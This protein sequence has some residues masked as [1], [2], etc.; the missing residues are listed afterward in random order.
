MD[1][2]YII[3]GRESC[4]YCVKA[5]N[6]LKRKNKTFHFLDLENEDEI[7][8]EVKEYYSHFTV[9]IVLKCDEHFSWHIVGGY[10][11][12]KNSL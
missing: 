5:K 12:L 7:L 9:P 3:F 4:P 6:L 1:K 8:L 10:S 2:E 11:E